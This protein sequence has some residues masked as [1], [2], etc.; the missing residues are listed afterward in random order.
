MS[1]INDKS[2]TIMIFLLF[3]MLIWRKTFFIELK[4]KENKKTSKS[5]LILAFVFHVL[6][7]VKHGICGWILLLSFSLFSTFVLFSAFFSSNNNSGVFLFFLFADYDEEFLIIF[8]EAFTGRLFL[9][10]FFISFCIPHPNCVDLSFVSCMQLCNWSVVSLVAGGHSTNNELKKKK[11]DA[12][13]S[14]LNLFHF[15]KISGFFS[16]DTH[17]RKQQMKKRRF[18]FQ[19]LIVCWVFSFSFLNLT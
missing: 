16:V 1:T 8:N 17:K 14:W 2:R 12:I 18:G 9:Q 6:S 3:S 4:K 13:K 19:R 7:H 10:F 11:H 15:F 5:D